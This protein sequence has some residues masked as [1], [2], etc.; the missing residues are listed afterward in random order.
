MISHRHTP[1]HSSANSET[2]SSYAASPS[3]RPESRSQASAGIGDPASFVHV[4]IALQNE[5]WPAPI[6]SIH[7]IGNESVRPQIIQLS[8]ESH[9]PSGMS[10]HNKPQITPNILSFLSNS[11]EFKSQYALNQKSTVLVYVNSQSAPIHM[12]NVPVVCMSSPVQ[13][14][15]WLYRSELV[16]E[17]WE[18]LCSSQGE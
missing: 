4:K 18:T 9:R 15:G 11:V 6:P 17:F 7:L 2:D 5:L 10:Y 14:S 12:E 3:P 16:S 8:P 1:E 13:Q